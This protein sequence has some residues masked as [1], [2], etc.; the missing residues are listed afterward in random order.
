MKREFAKIIIDH[1]TEDNTETSIAL[2]EFL[3]L[4][5]VLATKIILK[6]SLKSFQRDLCADLK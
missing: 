6:L 2:E 5:S 1:V 3:R 4:L